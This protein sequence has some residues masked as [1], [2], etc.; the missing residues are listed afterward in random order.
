MILSLCWSERANKALLKHFYIVAVRMAL[1]ITR[2]Q[3][4]AQ[5]ITQTRLTYKGVALKKMNLTFCNPG[6]ILTLPMHSI[7][8]V[9]VSLSLPPPETGSATTVHSSYCSSHNPRALGRVYLSSA[10][11]KFRRKKNGMRILEA[12]RISCQNV[13]LI[14]FSVHSF[15]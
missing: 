10:Q 14:C 15:T 6:E 3:K 5:I 7:C 11:Q 9:T 13:R 1:G 2:V 8:S 4:I 12:F